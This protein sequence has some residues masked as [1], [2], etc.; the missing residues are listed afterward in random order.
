M[1][2]NR[3]EHV[4]RPRWLIAAATVGVAAL[5]TV[6]IPALRHLREVPPPPPPPL[7]LVLPDEAVGAGAEYPFG[8]ALAPNGR[9]VAFPA[10][11]DGRVTL[12]LR[13]LET[14]DARALST[15]DGAAMPFW[16]TDGARL[17][18]FAGGRLHV[19]DVPS[20]TD[21]DAIA[22]PTPRGGAWLPSGD[23]VLA[24]VIAGG[25]VR[26][27]RG[28]QATEPLTEVD[29]ANGDLSHGMPAIGPDGRHVI[30]HVRA[31]TP[32]RSGVW[33]API[34]RPTDRR[35]LVGSDAHA[36]VS[37]GHL[38]FANDTALMAQRIDLEAGAL[39][40]RPT[41]IATPIGRGPLGQLFV[42]VTE[43]GPLLYGPPV[44]SQ[45]S[46]TWLDRSGT[47]IG[48]VG[49]P[50]SSWDV[51]V[52]PR[53]DRVAVTQVDAQLGTLDVWAYDGSRP[54]P[55]R[56]SAAI[57]TDDHAIWSPDASRLA[58]VRSRRSIIV[59]GAQAV[60]P[61]VT[62]HR[63]DGPVRLWDWS[64]NGLSLIVGLTDPITRDDLW[65]LAA[66]G[67]DDPRPLVRSPFSETEATVSPDGKWIAFASD[68]SG[69]NEIY[70]DSFPVP[71]QRARLTLGGGSMPRW[72][73]DGR[74]ITFRRGREIHAVTLTP[75]GATLE[76]AATTKL[77]ETAGDIRSYDVT[78]D[79]TRFLV[80]VPAEAATP[81]VQVIVNWRSLLMGSRFEM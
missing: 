49:A 57:E 63:F 27:R 16:S 13:D 69:H 17:A 19:F 5:V 45:R 41:M 79:G 56:I 71:S 53:G 75:A 54:L 76:A 12:W 4:I 58:W 43:Q 39:L 73:G 77:F 26:Y 44:S 59:R 18:Y 35:R 52:A 21:S 8:L 31:T 81:P 74:E 50:S 40:G 10:A 70:M 72:R 68:E 78:S 80:N 55:M 20:D 9:H 65:L 62:L 48:S 60:L 32:A 47:A 22:A 66:R 46:L 28:A 3:R 30:F 15:A 42:A 34:D 7:R 11:R 64:R 6:A 36:V 25:L 67:D 1:S 14:G 51:R 24:P 38:L 37:G 29:A 2:I 23:I 33:W 61:E